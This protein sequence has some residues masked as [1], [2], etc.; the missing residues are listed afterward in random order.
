MDDWV[1]VMEVRDLATGAVVYSQ[2]LDRNPETRKD[3]PEPLAL[4]GGPAGLAPDG[5]LIV[6][7]GEGQD[8][9]MFDPVEGR[10]T[11]SFGERLAAGQNGDANFDST[12]FFV[13]DGAGQVWVW[14]LAEGRLAAQVPTGGGGHGPEEG[15]FSDGRRLYIYSQISKGLMQAWTVWRRCR[16]SS[17][18]RKNSR[19]RMKRC[20]PATR[21]P[22]PPKCRIS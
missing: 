8:I 15:V 11:G 16:P 3:R 19:W 9:L 18:R 10:V 20:P 22:I 5:K 2:V 14:D 17:L 21:R 12:N 6:V 13:T 1:A 7:G 4:F